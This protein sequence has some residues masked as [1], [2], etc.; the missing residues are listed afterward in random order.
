ML[1]GARGSAYHRWRYGSGAPQT[2]EDISLEEWRF[3]NDINMDGVFLGCRAVIGAMARSGGG[4][5]VNISSIAGIRATPD[6]VAYG[7]SKGAVRQLTKALCAEW[8]K[9]NIQVNGI[10]PGYFETEMN[11]ALIDDAAFNDFVVGRTPAGRWG[12]VGELQG[13]AIFLASRASDFVNG[14]VIYVDGGVLAVI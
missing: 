2:I 6:I 14:Q 4:S 8:A 12:K 9:H 7:A 3:V 11:Q 13:A 10:G 1:A 5:I